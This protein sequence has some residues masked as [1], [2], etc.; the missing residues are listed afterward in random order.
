MKKL[1]DYLYYEEKDPSLKI[2]HGDCLEIM[3]LLPKVDLVV[4]DPPYPDYY[5]EEYG[6]KDSLIE[7]LSKIKTPMFCFWSAKCSFPIIHNAV[8]I[9]DKKVG[10]GSW[11][12]R[13]FECGTQT[14][15]YRVYRH[16][17]INSTVAAS[18]TCDYFANHP[19]Q[20]PIKLIKELIQENKSQTIL[21]PFLGS[22]TTLVACKELGRNGI[23]IEINEKYCEIAR[24]R[25]KNTTKSLF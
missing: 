19:S 22:G 15:E 13:I 12:E 1:D 11:Y 18:F 25:L 3:P 17:L 5:R 7:M 2:Y 6:Y 8:H 20:K 23:G 21:D 9:W 14:K 10:A 24:T 4:T 16:Y